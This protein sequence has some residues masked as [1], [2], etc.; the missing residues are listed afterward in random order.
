[1][2]NDKHIK[3]FNESLKQTQKF[4]TVRDLKLLLNSFDDDLPIGRR[5][6]FGEFHP[7]DAG[8]IYRSTARIV[9]RNKGWRS[10]ANEPTDILEIISYDIGEVPD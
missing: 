2:K 3:S 4:F 8:D 1:M 9:P 10:M 5:G 6:H 7:M